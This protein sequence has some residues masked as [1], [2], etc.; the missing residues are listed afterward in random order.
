MSKEVATTPKNK[1]A[2]LD[3]A[4]L[5]NAIMEEY[6]EDVFGELPPFA[7]VNGKTGEIVV[8]SEEEFP[9]DGMWL[10]VHSI[11]YGYVLWDDEG[12]QPPLD[13]QFRYLTQNP[14][15]IQEGELESKKGAS[16]KPFFDMTLK[17]MDS[18]AEYTFQSSTAS[19]INAM[20]ILLKKLFSGAHDLN[21]GVPVVRVEVDEF[22]MKIKGIVNTIYKPKF[23]LEDVREPEDGFKFDAPVLE[24][25]M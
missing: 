4:S 24:N 12:G 2:L 7:R 9:S 23:I 19:A 6:T 20:K 3:V 22:D 16:W 1:N 17:S 14:K 18:G 25:T 10:N 21:S 15:M 11:R 13:K 5:G 8:N